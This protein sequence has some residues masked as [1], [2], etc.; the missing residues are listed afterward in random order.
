M[1]MAIISQKQVLNMVPQLH[2]LFSM[3]VHY[4]LKTGQFLLAESRC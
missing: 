4:D 1:L 3:V 2:L